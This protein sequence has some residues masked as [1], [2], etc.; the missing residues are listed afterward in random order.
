MQR[1]HTLSL[2]CSPLIDVLKFAYYNIYMDENTIIELL[3][4]ETAAPKRRFAR[5][6]GAVYIALI[7]IMIACI[8]VGNLLYETRQIPRYVTQSVLYVLVALAGLYVYRRH[9]ICYRYTL[10]DEVFAIERIDGS[11]GR[12]IAV[13]PIRNITAIYD[14]GTYLLTRTSITHASLPPLNQTT[15]VAAVTDGKDAAYRVSISND[16]LGQL[17]GAMQRQSSQ[18]MPDRSDA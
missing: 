8:S 4:I 13:I 16:F 12:T 1:I 5:P 6:K 2:N 3:A 15:L 18:S 7:A 14:G 10:T 17:R 9:Y 11:K